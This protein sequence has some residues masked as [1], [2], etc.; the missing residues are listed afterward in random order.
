MAMGSI[1]SW[2]SEKQNEAKQNKKIQDKCLY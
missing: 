1:F 2:F